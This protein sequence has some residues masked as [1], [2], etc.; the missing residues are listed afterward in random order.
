MSCR[1][2]ILLCIDGVSRKLVEEA[3]CG[4]YAEPENPEAIANAV[5]I[6]MANSTDLHKMGDSGYAYA[7]A[8]FDRDKLADEYLHHLISVKENV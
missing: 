6:L 2:P 3:G 4:I 8:N 1:V 5:K 7:K